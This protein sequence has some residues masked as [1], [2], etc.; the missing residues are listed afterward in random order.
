M[1]FRVSAEK[2]A[3]SLMGVPLYITCCFSL[4]AFNILS[5]SLIFPILITMCLGVVLLRLSYLR[6]FCAFWTWLSVFFHRLGKFSAIMSLNMFSA[7]F[8]VSYLLGPLQ[9]ECYYTS[10]VF[11]IVLIS[12][13]SFFFF[14]FNFSDFHYSVF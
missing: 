8:C 4:A 3:S 7:P 11:K 5:I 14:L 10:E 6:L 2:L 12:F 9:C 13:L 1:A